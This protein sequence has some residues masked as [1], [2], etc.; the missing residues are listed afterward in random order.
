MAVGDV[1]LVA[2]GENA[3][4]WSLRQV[5]EVQ[6]AFVAMDVNTLGALY[7]GGRDAM[8]FGRVGR[9]KGS[10]EAIARLDGFF[11]T[12]VAPWIQEVF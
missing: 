12:A 9:I 7:L 5:P 8:G 4:T 6:G 2:E 1:I 10:P 3:N 11:R